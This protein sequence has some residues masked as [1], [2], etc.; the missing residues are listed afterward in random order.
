LQHE[1]EV[2]ETNLKAFIQPLAD[3]I[4]GSDLP[5][6][7]KLFGRG[8]TVTESPFASK[9]NQLVDALAGNL[10]AVGVP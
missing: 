5:Q 1:A 6:R 4:A 8:I 10:L 9:R 7:A 2:G 3:D